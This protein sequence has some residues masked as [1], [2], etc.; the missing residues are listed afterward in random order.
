MAISSLEYLLKLPPFEHL[1]AKTIEEACSLLGRYEDRAKVIAGGTDLLVLMKKRRHNP[2]YLINIKAIPDLDY[3][4]Y[5]EPEG[6]RIGPLAALHAIAGSPIIKEKFELLS[7]ACEKIGTPQIRNMGTIGGNICTGG[8]SQDSVPPLL[9]LEA[10]LRL[11]SSRGERL[12]PIEEFF[13]APFQTA[14]NSTELLAEIQ[15]PA[16]P[17]HSGGD[18]QWFTKMTT[19]DETLVGVAV[20]I[21]L[22]AS[23]NIDDI[24]I[25]LGSVAPTPLRAYHA[26]ALLRGKTIETKLVDQAAQ[27]VAEETHP[28]SRVDYRRQMTHLLVTQAITAA[29]QKIK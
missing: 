17:P 9:V 26:E 3:I 27:V 13:I 7:V 14:I 29:W 2:Q 23:G 25:G 22:G 24:K 15:I 4:R 21:T 11:T 1:E 20:L 8:P 16:P 28:R 5:S 19:V 12:V 18:Y 10:K 6:L